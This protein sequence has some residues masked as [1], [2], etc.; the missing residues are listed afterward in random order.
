MGHTR[1]QVGEA[2]E[3]YAANVGIRYDELAR[4]SKVREAQG[5]DV[6][7]GQVHVCARG[8]RGEADIPEL[9]VRVYLRGAVE[10]RCSEHLQHAHR[11]MN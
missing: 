2:G 6:Q 10:I 1:K 8:Q 3:L 9:E 4:A 5:F 7:V 11:P